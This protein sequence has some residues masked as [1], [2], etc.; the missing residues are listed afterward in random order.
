MP[1]ALIA[2]TPRQQGVA[3]LDTESMLH[4]GVGLGAGIAG[5][6]PKMALLAALM[7]EAILEVVKAQTTKAL[8]DTGHGQ[9]K[10]NEI[11]DLLSLAFGAY[12][13]KAIRERVSAPPVAVAPVATETVAGL[14]NPGKIIGVTWDP[15]TKR[16]VF[17]E[18]AA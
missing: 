5:V 8:F 9:S 17:L 3:V 11:F 7:A 2:R 13:G 10:I 1:E 12:L 14:G 6:D 4:F 16:Y 15:V 18:A